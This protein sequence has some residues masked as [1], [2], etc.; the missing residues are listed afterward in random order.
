MLI[1][2]DAGRIQIQHQG[3]SL[4]NSL[5][6]RN[7]AWTSKD[8]NSTKQSEQNKDA[9]KKGGREVYMY[10]PRPPGDTSWKIKFKMI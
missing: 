6:R 8:K 4:R 5:G 1:S 9:K 10:T 3:D 7:K 2:Q